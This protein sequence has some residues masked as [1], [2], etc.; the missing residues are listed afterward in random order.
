[1]NQPDAIVIGSGPNG[2]A[3]AIVI[4]RAGRKVLV[5]EAE[6]T[7]GG[8]CRSAELT[9]PGFVH[10]VC[11]AVH[12]LAV[13]SPLFRTLPLEQ[14]GLRWITPPLM[15]AHPLDDG[16]AAV[17]AKS[18][19]ETA[20]QMGRDAGAY[21]RL[22]GTIVDAWPQLET[23]VLGPLRM[24]KHPVALARFG[25]KAIQ[26]ASQL[27][28][29]RFSTAGA[30][31]LFG[32]IAAHGMLP[33]D[34]RP[35][36]AFGLVLGAAAH[37]AGWVIPRGGSQS[38]TDALAAYLRSLGGE[39]AVGQRVISIDDLPPARAV[40]C[41][42]SPRPLLQI[43]GHRF[44]DWYRQQLEAYRYAGGVFKVDYAL[45]TPIPW[46]AAACGRAGTVHLGGTLEEI[47]RGEREAFEGRAPER[48]FVLLTQPSV[49]DPTRA[50]ADRQTAWAYCH[51]PHGSS[52]DM[53]PRIEQQI[54]RFAPGFRDRV[55]ARSVLRPADIERHNANL[56]GGDIGAGLSDL[57][58]LFLRPTRM[59]YS[60]P[61]RG[62]YICSAST[63]PGV[64]VHGM[65]GYH[66][67]E[68]ALSEVLG[69]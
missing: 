60:T 47:A 69:D 21:S 67:A 50:P 42:L 19:K 44:P 28:Q 45:E 23:S 10:D 53:L 22:F 26:A 25:L 64:G 63:P 16:N 4:A 49:F 29:R 8:G 56:V 61:V 48:P 7:I 27:A 62:L 15:L 17:V 51:V 36:A 57:R 20:A 43:A 9:L 65:C 54:E 52:E 66:A 31:A 30:R 3:A 68:R 5:L 24:P 37:V 46:R 59:M 14:H 58:Q 33:L 18:V 34:E 13:A 40:L 11:S 2:L 39:I 38:L 32:G 55:L 35:T 12:P 6:P 41:D 1:M